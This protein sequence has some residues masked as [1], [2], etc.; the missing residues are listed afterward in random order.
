M[1]KKFDI[2]DDDMETF[3]PAISVTKLPPGVRRGRSPRQDYLDIPVNQIV[4]FTQ[5][6]KGDFSRMESEAFSQLVETVKQDGILEACIVRPWADDKF[7]MLAGETRWRAAQE[8]GLLTIPCR[9]IANCD[10]SQAA[11]IFSVTNLNRRDTTIRDRLYGWY[12][13]WSAVKEQKADKE[14]LLQEDVTSLNA[15]S[16]TPGDLKLRQI[17]KY[18][19]IYQLEEPFLRSIELKQLSLEAAYA[20]AFLKPSEREDLIGFN[21]SMTQAEELKQLSKSGAWSQEEIDRILGR[22]PKGRS[23]QDA[24][25]RRAVRKFKTTITKRLNP[26][27]YND[28]DK[29]LDEAMKLY[30]EKHPEDAAD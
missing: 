3:D 19:K 26:A 25:M 7:E 2:P 23:E 17:Q 9:V 5:K 27:R 14:K 15:S 24:S 10:D 11:R 16:I 13:Y 4:A 30:F 20:L 22:R 28:V 29:I 12:I 1:A 18:Y 8:A 6:G 21:I